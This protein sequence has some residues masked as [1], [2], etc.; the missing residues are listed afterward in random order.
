MNF[1]KYPSK[2]GQTFQEIAGWHAKI[3]P[4]SNLVTPISNVRGM[5]AQLIFFAWVEDAHSTLFK[6]S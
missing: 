2:N 4:E 1:R 6:Y 3:H 5:E